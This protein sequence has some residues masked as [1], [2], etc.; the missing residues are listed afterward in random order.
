MASYEADEARAAAKLEHVQ[1]LESGSTASDVARQ[2]LDTND[3][4]CKEKKLVAAMEID[5]GRRTK[6]MDWQ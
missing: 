5:D 3:A 4:R 1:T 2:D 6:K